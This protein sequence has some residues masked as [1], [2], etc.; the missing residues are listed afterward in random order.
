[1]KMNTGPAFL[2]GN[3]RVCACN[4]IMDLNTVNLLPLQ[5]SSGLGTT[6]VQMIL[7]GQGSVRQ[8]TLEYLLWQFIHLQWNCHRGYAKMNLSIDTALIL[9]SCVLNPTQDHLCKVSH[10]SY[11]CAIFNTARLQAMRLAL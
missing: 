11:F 6:F 7:K 10:C 3:N 8:P 9:S 5:M 4:D 1:M 2:C